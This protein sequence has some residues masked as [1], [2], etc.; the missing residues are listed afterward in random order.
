MLAG[1]G[2]RGKVLAGGQSLVPLMSMRLSAPEHLVDVNHVPGLDGVRRRRRRG[3]RGGAGAAQPGGARRGGVRRAAAA[4]P[5][6][7]PGGPPDDPQ[8]GHDRGQPGARRP[9]RRDAGGAAAARRVGHAAQRRRLPRGRRRRTFFVGPMESAVRAGELAVSATFRRPPPG[10]GS[11]F[12]EVA[13]RQGDYAVCGVGAV[14]GA[15]HGAGA[16]WSSIG[17]PA[18]CWSTSP[19]RTTGPALDPDVRPRPGRRRDRPGGRHPRQRRLPPPPRARAGA[20]GR[21]ARRGRS[22]GE[23]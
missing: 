12:V 17:R 3:A 20:R 21:C 18:R 4:A 7:A 6:A 8:P 2:E 15:R 23:A 13:R 19:R 10:S 22:V 11:A 14:V 16:R 1:L 9:G 5:G